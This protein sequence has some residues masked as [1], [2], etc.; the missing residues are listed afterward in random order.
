MTEEN[1]LT[2]ET[3]GC[4]GQARAVG[5]F[6]LKRYKEAA[7]VYDELLKDDPENIVFWTN[8]MICR[9][10]HS[11]VST[12]FFDQMVQRVSR[13]PAEGYL[14]LAEVLN[15]L[16]RQEEALVFVNKALEKSADNIS[17][18]VFK[19]L[20][21]FHLERPDEL[22]AFM[23][24]LYLRFK[25]DERILCLAAFY[26]SLFENMQQADH[27]L[28]KALKVNRAAVLQ[29]PLF[30]SILSEME[31]EAQIIEYGL[32]A[33]TACDE[34]QDVWSAVSQAYITLE[35]YEEADNALQS[36]SCLTDLSEEMQVQWVYVL[37]ELQEYD[38]AF[39]LLLQM[40]EDSEARLLQIREL[41]WNMR[42][43]GLEEQ[44]RQK[45]EILAD[46]QDI[47]EETRFICDA[48]LN[49]ERKDSAPVSLVRLINDAYAQ[50]LS[51]IALSSSYLGPSLLEET[52]ETLEVPLAESLNAA[53]LGCGAGAMAAVLK[54][55]TLFD[56][57]LV[58]VDLSSETL[59]LAADQST[60]D[61][62]QEADLI[63]F[64]KSKKNAKQYDLIVCMDVLSCFADLAPVFKAVKSAL[65]PGGRF[66]FSIFP[67][68][69]K[70]RPFSFNAGVFHH[71]ADFVSAALKTSRLQE[72][73]RQ[74]GI[75]YR[76]EE[77]ISCL[78]FAAQK[79]K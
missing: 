72:I 63:S 65:K 30:Y 17:A 42:Q 6:L 67:L 75:L 78:I 77:D 28:K 4:T 14:C 8:R 25:A 20:L 1:A 52:L 5:L 53:D 46:R 22:Y 24:S 60:Y 18:N 27:F 68:T 29:D 66:V 71:N 58:G 33:L 26:A 31:E 7:T 36:L 70:E 3:S 50:E 69:G 35:E 23:D 9:L 2:Q 41:F 32:E 59:E 62:L 37:F 13:L 73:Y 47:S 19:A 49:R 34:N 15:N 45:A 11:S 57:A 54:K 43:A 16:G 79:K 39:D 38:R 40:P 56:G 64:C 76:G 55:Y 74:E 48:V 61:D 10:Q 51:D 21:L 12:A 44:C